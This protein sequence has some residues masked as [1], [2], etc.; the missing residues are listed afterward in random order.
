MWRNFYIETT[1]RN[2]KAL[3]QLYKKNNIRLKLV[4]PAKLNSNKEIKEF[5]SE[6]T[7]AITFPEYHYLMDQKKSRNYNTYD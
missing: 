7:K 5:A 4:P 1:M 6:I 3:E 2:Y